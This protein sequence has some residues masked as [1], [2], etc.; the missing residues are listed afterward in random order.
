MA[1][2]VFSNITSEQ[3]SP[4]EQRITWNT[5]ILTVGNAVKYGRTGN[6]GSQTP[7]DDTP[8]SAHSI[9]IS[10]LQAGRSYHFAVGGVEYTIPGDLTLTPSPV[11][12]KGALGVPS[13]SGGNVTAPSPVVARAISTGATILGATTDPATLPSLYARLRADD[14]PGLSALDPIALWGDSSGNGHDVIQS[15]VSQRFTFRPALVGGRDAVTADGVDDLMASTAFSGVLSM[16]TT[17]I[18]VAR[19]ADASLVNTQVFSGLNSGLRHVVYVAAGNWQLYTDPGPGL[20][21]PAA[22]SDQWV[23][24][25]AIFDGTSSSLRINGGTATTGTLTVTALDGLLIGNDPGIGTPW[26]GDIAEVI[27]F[28]DHL[29]NGEEMG[30]VRFL[31]NYYGITVG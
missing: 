9:T 6:Y 31:G 21:G 18:A 17:V 15:S 14:I 3:V 24:V 4:S 27:L 28:N 7:P 10:G 2:P 5:D 29:N 11:A 23:V 8:A 25:S 19:V 20:I 12:A 30:V 16:P 26:E 13:F 22:T 1:D